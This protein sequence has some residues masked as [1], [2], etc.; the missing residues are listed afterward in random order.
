[1]QIEILLIKSLFCLLVD[2]K[3]VM[4]FINH[5]IAVDITINTTFMK[6]CQLTNQYYIFLQLLNYLHPFY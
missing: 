3:I 6:E 4:N 2:Q 5:V 1:M